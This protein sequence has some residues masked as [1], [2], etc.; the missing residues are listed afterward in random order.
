MKNNRSR[1]FHSQN[2]IVMVMNSVRHLNKLK[3]VPQKT[4]HLIYLQRFNG[5]KFVESVLSIPELN[6]AEELKRITLHAFAFKTLG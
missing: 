1:A 2:S 4:A 5:I 6:N 3:T